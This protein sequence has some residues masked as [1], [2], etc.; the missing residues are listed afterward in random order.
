MESIVAGQSPRRLLQL[1]RGAR[2][3]ADHARDGRW[4][5]A[6]VV[7]VQRLAGVAG[8]GVGAEELGSS[9]VRILGA[10]SAPSV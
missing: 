9:R 1:L 5:H 8:F 7:D 6:P 3:D 2:N 10:S 4:N